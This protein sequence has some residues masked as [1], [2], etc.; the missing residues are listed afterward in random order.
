MG[1]IPYYSH[2]W[3]FILNRCLYLLTQALLLYFGLNPL[4]CCLVYLLI[5][6]L[7]THASLLAR[8]LHWDLKAFISL[9][10]KRPT[11]Q[12]ATSGISLKPWNT[13]SSRCSNILSKFKS[14]VEVTPNSV[15]LPEPCLSQVYHGVD[16]HGAD[17]QTVFT[18]D[19][20]ECHKACTNDPYCQFFTF[21]NGNSAEYRWKRIMSL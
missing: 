6:D 10:A 8:H 13:D 19:H 5:V 2:I 9:R 1:Y 20:E 4:P 11:L 7:N 18:A 16:F 17:Y 15:C 21:M 12:G 14:Y 3:Y